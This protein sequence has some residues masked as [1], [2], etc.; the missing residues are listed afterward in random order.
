M[1]EVS[2]RVELYFERNQGFALC[3]WDVV[4]PI[5]LEEVPA[6][7][8]VGRDHRHEVCSIDSVTE[9]FKSKAGLKI[10]EVF[11]VRSC[12]RV[13][14]QAVVSPLEDTGERRVD[15]FESDL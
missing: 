1:D 14:D 9:K 5:V 13:T 10:L 2:F 11:V 3:G 12:C 7:L 6:I 4:G 8:A 15:R